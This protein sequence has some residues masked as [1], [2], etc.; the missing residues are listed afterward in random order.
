MTF[1]GSDK[2]ILD[3][4]VHHDI[5]PTIDP[6]VHYEA[7]TFKGKVVFIT[8]ASRGIGEE[9]ALQYARAG[10]F[11]ALV[12]REQRTLDLVKTSIL[13]EVPKVQVLTFP[14]DVV[15]TQDMAQAV[16]ATVD[17]FGRLDI[18]V[19]NAAQAR[20]MDEPFAQR[21][22]DGWWNVIEVN[23]RG[24][25]NAVHFAIPH[26]QKINGHSVIVTSCAAN[27]RI[28]FASDYCISKHALVRLVEYIVLENPS[29]KAFAFHPGVIPTR[30]GIESLVP[31]PLVDTVAL[32][33]ASTLHLTTG[34]ADW[35]TG[36]FVSANW[37][38]DALERNW[39]TKIVEQ[40]V[41]VSKLSLPQ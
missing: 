3:I 18:L 41:L 19:A 5:Y 36:R 17:R 1:I 30:I 6:K 2:D 12:G 23:L 25:Y 29:V 4:E 34:K 37:D 31:L 27:V 24:V 40:N 8:G 35:L 32:A 21:D 33:A 13:E 15:R 10:A 16:Q 9:T 22:P 39:K 38:L 11:L 26:L 14:V 20:P 28:P 7:Q